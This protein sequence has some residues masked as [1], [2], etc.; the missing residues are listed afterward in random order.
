M[1]EMQCYNR[2]KN[3][4]YIINNRGTLLN[5]QISQMLNLCHIY[6]TALNITRGKYF[7]CLV[8]KCFNVSYLDR[9]DN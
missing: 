4:Y 7:Q 1:T 2:M 8:K 6:E 5:R 9:L 3:I